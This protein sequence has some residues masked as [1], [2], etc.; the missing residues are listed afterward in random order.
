MP[1]NTPSTGSPP[2]TRSRNADWSLLASLL[3]Y[4]LAVAKMWWDIHARTG[5]ISYTVDDAYIHGTLARNLSEHG[6][7]GIVPGEFSAASS[8]PL[9]TVLLAVIFLVTGPLPWIPAVLATL[10][11]GLIVGRAHFLMKDAGAGP[12]SRLVVIL[13]AM[14]YA[15]L[16]PIIS[17]GMEHTMH[18]WAIL[19]LFCAL[20]TASD[21]TKRRPGMVFLW[22]AMAAGV[23]YESL[24]ALPPLLLWLAW[25][26]KWKVA[27]ELG[28]GMAL[29]VLVFAVYSLSHG[30]YA[31]PN[32]L[33]LKGNLAGAW[34][35]RAFRVLFENQYM[36]M[37]V[38]F[39]VAASTAC[40]FKRNGR[41][42]LWVPVSAIMMI[43][44]HL[45][46]AQLGWFWRYEG[47]LIVLGMVAAAPLLAWLNDVLKN[48]PLALV[49]P[50][51]V[52]LA[53]ATLPLFW[54]F[55]RSVREI[56][57]A[58]G[59]IHDQQLQM[60]QVIRHLGKGARVAV[61]DLGAMSFLTD[62]WVL[63]LWGL[64][65]NRIAR[66]K[67]EKRHG[68]A[69]LKQRIDEA[70]IDFV[71]VYPDWF[72]PPDDLPK[73]LI[74]VESWLLRENLICGDDTVVFYGTTQ[75]AADRMAAA[76]NQYRATNPI[77]P[78]STNEMQPLVR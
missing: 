41:G 51:Y 14:A 60:A 55:N 17:T 8:S 58:A 77:N 28:C 68:A 12:A 46:L 11:G 44:I 5:E 36:L 31:L 23:R 69:M 4:A 42:K 24:F 22:A 34:K 19:G 25:Q 43:L 56:V 37:L 67:I 35:I 39:L 66:A 57:P 73:S 63:D 71:I 32:S 54:R 38:L 7:L 2:S 78:L 27:F 75:A 13:M 61:N 50:V 47:Y 52:L 45:Q 18:A 70:R 9:W 1:E 49:L 21:G 74:P 33:M 65:D 48:K 3:V 16:L 76:L 59:N 30:G 15:P 6:V 40:I 10:C 72:G 64:G 20:V 29:P 53:Y 26:R 62:A